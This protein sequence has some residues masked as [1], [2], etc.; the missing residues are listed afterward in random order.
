MSTALFFSTIDVTRQ[1]F[2]RSSLSY[3]IVN[4]KP[5][6]AGHVLVIP[7]RPAPRLG[8]LNDQELSSLML[9][10]RHVGNVIERAYS[11]D[12]LTIACQDGKAAGQSIPHVHFHILPRRLRGD[13]FEKSNDEIYPAL[14]EN[15]KMLPI[16]FGV[17]QIGNVE[18]HK[19]D[20][21]DHR[22]PRSF[23]EME[24]EADW[25]KGFFVHADMS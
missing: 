23:E 10:V 22:A 1:C 21:D 6:V 19:V 7:Q 5:I 12:A 15:E 11:A 3:A 14:E 17:A 8:D 4:L 13:Q 2:Y 16:N 9:S 20:A 18:R 24:N 25:L